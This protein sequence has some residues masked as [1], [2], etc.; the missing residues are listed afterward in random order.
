M[1]ATPVI[2]GDKIYIANGQDPESGI[3]PASLYAIDAS[4]RG[5]ITA[6][7]LVWRYGE[8]KRFISSV[9]IFN[10]LLFAADLNGF[11]HCLD[12]NTGKPYWTH[13]MMSAIWA[14]PMVI[15]GKL[16]VGDADGDVVV[17]EA[18]KE[19]KL[20]FHHRYGQQRLFH[21]RTRQWHAVSGEPR[22]AIRAG[23]TMTAMRLI[24][25]LV[26]AVAIANAADEWA[27]FR[28]NSQ[29]TGVAS[30]SLPANLKLIWTYD[31][32]EGI[33]SSAAIAGEVVYVGSRSKDLLAIDLQTGKL[34]WKNR[35]ND[36]IDESSPTVSG[37]IVY[38]G[39]VGGALH[40]VDAASGKS[41]WTFQ[42][43]AEIRSS[44][45]V[46]GDRLLIGS[47]DGSLYCLSRRDGKLLWKVPTDNYVHSTPAIRDGVAYFSGCDENIHGIRLAD[48]QEIAKFP[49]GG[50]TAASMALD[51]QRAYYGTFDNVVL[52]VDLV[53][54]SVL[55][56][57]APGAFPF[58]SS[59]AFSGDRIIVGGRDKLVHA[60]D[61]KSG[62]AIWT[63]RTRARVDSSPAIAGGRVYIG[64]NDGRFYV[65]D[66]AS[67]KKL[68]E[69]EAGA[70]LS[71][72]PAIA[73]GRVVIGDLAGHLFCFG[74]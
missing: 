52:G 10:G 16:Y 36:A 12:G 41:L 9:A 26:L 74:Q 56:R 34:K 25:I 20:L 2:S 24:S 38:V 55:W 70:P 60:I 42:S 71:A 50:P 3:G 6:T 32:G 44:P 39:D 17:M 43:E 40:A 63:F 21:L 5:D 8:I 29:L 61:V 37:G 46:S 65:L 51:G 59:P 53:A 23:Q 28:G 47:Y 35:G 64:S 62:K 15:D 13:D 68:W 4:K 69:Y 45:V 73:E 27:Q 7:G 18:A 57:Y 19:K 22:Y 1:V 66:L 67:G 72:S 11:L 31:A 54:K 49:S 33:N 48:G 14:S 30:G 58:Y